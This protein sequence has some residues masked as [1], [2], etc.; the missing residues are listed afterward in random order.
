MPIP[1][2]RCSTIWD[3]SKETSNANIQLLNIT[4]K[5]SKGSK[6]DVLE[7]I[8]VWIQTAFDIERLRKLAN[9][10]PTKYFVPDSIWKCFTFVYQKFLI[11][12]WFLTIILPIKDTAAKSPRSI[13]VVFLLY[14]LD[15]INWN[16]R[17]KW[18]VLIGL[19]R[20]CLKGIILL[21]FP[22]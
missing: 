10:F 16:N 21:L 15:G 14:T 17:R 8:F 20:K 12:T 7:L 9:G 6:S 3:K 19:K 18:M 22:K 2:F 13:S 5:S 4:F 1:F 11:P